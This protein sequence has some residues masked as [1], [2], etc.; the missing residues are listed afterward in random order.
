MTSNNVKGV[1]FDLDGDV[2]QNKPHPAMLNFALEKMG[3]KKDDTFFV[4]D[5]A[6][7][8]QTAQNAGMKFYAVPTGNTP[9]EALEEARP[10][11]VLS[12]F[13]DLIEYVS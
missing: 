3:L 5:S 2:L 9:R 13:L 7:D 4:G 8:I 10:T 12:R 6:I 1:I 11:A